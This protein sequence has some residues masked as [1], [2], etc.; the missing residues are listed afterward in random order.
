[1]AACCRQSEHP[2]TAGGF[3]RALDALF[4]RTP[5]EALRFANQ[6]AG[7]TE[8]RSAPE[9]IRSPVSSVFKGFL[10]EMGLGAGRARA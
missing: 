6:L 4:D 1:M 7:E 5:E 8:R 2:R 3:D 9:I 10:L